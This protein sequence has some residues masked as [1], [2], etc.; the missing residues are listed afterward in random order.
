TA[1]AGYLGLVAGVGL[2]E[3]I[4]ALLPKSDFFSNPAV[5]LEVALWAT[6]VLVF[7]G[8]LAGFIPAYSAAKVSPVVA[9]RDE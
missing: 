2:L 9:M 7:S 6:G 4:A 5:D 1:V 3:T 8:A